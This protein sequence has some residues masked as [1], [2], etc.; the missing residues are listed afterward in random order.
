MAYVK[1]VTDSAADIPRALREE[2][3]IQVLPFP[4]AMGDKEYEDGYDFTPEEFYG[5][6]LSAPQIPTH[7]Q[8]NPYVFEQCFEQAYDNGYTHLIYTSINSK[9]SATHQNAVQA[10]EEF[11]EEHPEARENF[12]I[13]IIDS[14]NYTMTYG[15]GHRSGQ[16]SGLYSGLAG[17]RAGALCPAGPALC[18]EVGPCVGGRRLCGRRPGTQAHHD[19]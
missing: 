16:G 14:R 10:R 5:M 19:F 12:Q 6:L 13:T 9:G 18:Q 3:D 4:I 17:P 11:Y 2:L 7:A 1:M 15:G 8:L